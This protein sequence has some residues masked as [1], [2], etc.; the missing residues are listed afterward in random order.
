MFLIKE[1]WD[2]YSLVSLVSDRTLVK[3]MEMAK[4]IC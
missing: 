1:E 3:G 4:D 2:N